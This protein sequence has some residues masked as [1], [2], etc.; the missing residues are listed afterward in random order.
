MR[1]KLFT[2]KN[3]IHL[4]LIEKWFDMT[5]SGNKKEEYRDITPYWEKAFKKLF[6]LS[7][8]GENYIPIVET[9]TFSN[10]YAKDRKQFEIEHKS[11]RIGYGNIKWG[12][13]KGVKYFILQHGNILQS[14]FN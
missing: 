4:N 7:H 12:A 1:K 10:G 14:N 13:K 5:L 11:I 2:T 6:P 9:I 8:Q 3:T